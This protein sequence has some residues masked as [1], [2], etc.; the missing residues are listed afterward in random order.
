MDRNIIIDRRKTPNKY[1]SASVIMIHKIRNSSS[2]NT[3]DNICNLFQTYQTRDFCPPSDSV[4]RNLT[5]KHDD[6]KRLQAEFSICEDCGIYVET[7][8]TKSTLCRNCNQKYSYQFFLGSLKS[9]LQQILH[10]KKE[11]PWPFV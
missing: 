7:K 6:I 2:N 1:D 8:L 3:I 11:R 4:K 10:F 5:K 9:Q